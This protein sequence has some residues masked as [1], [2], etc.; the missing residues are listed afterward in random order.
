[1]RLEGYCVW[2]VWMDGYRLILVKPQGYHH[3]NMISESRHSVDAQSK[4]PISMPTPMFLCCNAQEIF[5]CST[6]VNINSG[7]GTGQALR[8]SQTVASYFR[9]SLL[10]LLNRMINGLPHFVRCIRPNSD[11]LPARW[12]RTKVLEQLKYTGVLETCRIRREGFSHRILF[13]EFIH[14]YHLLA[15][16]PVGTK[17]V[18]SREMCREVLERLALHNWRLGRT[19]VFLKYYHMEELARRHEVLLR[20]VVRCQAVVRAW[21]ARHRLRAVRRAARVLQ[22]RWR[23]QLAR[24]DVGRI[25]A[26]RERAALQIQCMVRGYMVRKITSPY[27]KERQEAAL[28]IQTAARGFLVRRRFQRLRSVVFIQAAWRGHL[29]RRNL[30]RKLKQRKARAAAMVALQEQQHRRLLQEQERDNSS[31]RPSQV[32][33][34]FWLVVYLIRSSGQ[35]ELLVMVFIFESC[36]FYMASE[37]VCWKQRS[38]S[39]F[40]W[41]LSSWLRE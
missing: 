16:G 6:Q 22:T 19:K 28:V 9:H 21:L 5:R 29:T 23:G 33:I 37:W 27:Y 14:R 7:Y 3:H 24:R 35:V 25:V 15:F 31:K 36:L 8:S 26:R 10:D 40:R 32:I 20:R 2:C 12:D 41:S 34:A 18:V 4:T 1:M 39:V 11:N 38:D 13:S 30:K 17:L